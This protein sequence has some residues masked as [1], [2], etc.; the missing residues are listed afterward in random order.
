MTYFTPSGMTQS[1]AN[2]INYARHSTANV[3]VSGKRWRSPQAQSSNDL[4]GLQLEVVVENQAGHKLP[5]GV[6][7]RRAFLEVEVL[8]NGETR[9]RSGG[10]NEWGVIVDTEGKPLK[11]EFFCGNDPEKVEP[12]YQ[13]HYDGSHPITSDRQVQIYEELIKDGTGRFTTSFLSLCDEVKDNRL[14]PRGWDPRG[15]EA[16]ETRPI[17]RAAEDTTYLNG[18]AT[19]Q[20]R[21]E[22]AL[23][24]SEED[25][26]TVTA[27]LYYQALPPYYLAQRFALLEKSG[28]YA[29]ES[30]YYYVNNLQVDNLELKPLPENWP[31][32]AALQDWKLRVASDQAQIGPPGTQGSPPG[33]SGA[34]QSKSSR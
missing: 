20:T 3:S 29:T 33:N 34:A 31:I 15:P 8:V 2:S 24:L 17:G 26:V 1:L 5:S 11:T 32:Q 27:Q 25:E 18:S 30:L 4:D 16:E 10:T 21:Y 12:C 22:L 6:G 9:W 14:M 19:S 28:S 13:Q 7:F 23:G